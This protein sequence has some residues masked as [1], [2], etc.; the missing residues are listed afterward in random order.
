MLCN[1]WRFHGIDYEECCLLGYKI[2]VRT[3]QETHYVSTTEPSQLM[4]C[5]I[6]G[7]HSS[8]YEECRLLGYKPPVR[9]SQETHYVSAREPSQLILCKMWGFYGGDYEE[10]RLLGC[11]VLART[12]VSEEIIGSII[13]V[14]RIGES[15]TTL[16]VISNR[17]TPRSSVVS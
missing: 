4:L 10:C 16:A 2:P 5:K 13:R 6:W 11:V 7:F 14:T 15:G 12:E 3:S 9:T 8:D 1:I 17:S